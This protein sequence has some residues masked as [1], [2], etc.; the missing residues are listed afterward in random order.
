MSVHRPHVAII[1]LNWNQPEYTLACLRSLGQLEYPNV[2]VTV[3]DNGST[4]GS[5]ALIRARYPD[6]TLI[7]N[8]R[9]LGFAAGNNVGIDLAMRDGADYVMLLNNDT[10]VAPDMVDDLIAVAE[11]DSSI[12]IVGPKILYYDLPD[13]I[14]SAGGTIDAY[15]MPGHV[16][17]DQPDDDP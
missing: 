1:L 17:A 5:P 9:N 13:T 3:V 14:W 7:E 6:V 2:T 8:G 12:G 11:S 4:D 10:E 15:G 16:G